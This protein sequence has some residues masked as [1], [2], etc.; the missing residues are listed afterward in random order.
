MREECKGC[1]WYG[2]G[3]VLCAKLDL[4]WAWYD[5]QKTIPILRRMAQ[6]PE[7]CWGREEI[8]EEE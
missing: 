5:L 2:K 1:F 8:M 6:E 4:S 3:I 7:P